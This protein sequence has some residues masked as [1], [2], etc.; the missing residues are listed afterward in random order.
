MGFISQRRREVN[1]LEGEHDIKPDKIIIMSK[2]RLQ[3]ILVDLI[4][5]SRKK[6]EFCNQSGSRLVILKEKRINT[7]KYF[8]NYMN[9]KRMGTCSHLL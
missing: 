3:Q 4:I 8:S 5:V 6:F 1:G 7:Q 2:D 9:E